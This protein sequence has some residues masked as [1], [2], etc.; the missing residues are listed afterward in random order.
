MNYTDIENFVLCG[1]DKLENI[2]LTHDRHYDIKGEYEIDKCND[3][4]LVFL[5]PMPTEEFLTSLYPVTY[6]SYQDFY[7]KKQSFFKRFVKKYLLNIRTFDPVFK[8]PGKMLDIG[9]G[10]GQFLFSMKKKGW[11]VHGV[12]VNENAAKLGNELENLNIHIGSLLTSN[13]ETDSFDYIRSNHSFEHMTNPKEV[14]TEIHRILKPG[15]KLLIGVHNIDSFNARFFKKYWWYLGAPTHT[16]NYSV[17][18]LSKML[19][20]CGFNVNKVSYNGDFGGTLGSIQIYLNRNNGKMSDNGFFIKNPLLIVIFHK[21][22]KVL[23]FFKTGD[24]ME[25]ISSKKTT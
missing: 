13:Y 2:Y 1:S 25:I 17:A 21:L 20:Q 24:A 18:T 7:E 4:G 6:Y 10:S 5:N 11:E 9:C 19:D 22:A 14:L 16:F 8:S 23:N 3:C 15:G 12:E